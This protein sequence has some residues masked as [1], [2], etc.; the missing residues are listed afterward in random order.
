MKRTNLVPFSVPVL[1]RF[2]PDAFDGHPVLLQ[3]WQ[4]C[5]QC[6]GGAVVS[7]FLLI[8]REPQNSLGMLMTA[9]DVSSVLATYSIL[10]PLCGLGIN[11]EG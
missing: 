6:C 1:D 10:E 7:F 5:M 3:Q 4:E 9:I 11:S 2:A 8:D